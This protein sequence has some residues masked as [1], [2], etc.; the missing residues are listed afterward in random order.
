VE[1]I[2]GGLLERGIERPHQLPP[3]S[4]SSLH[5]SCGMSCWKNKEIHDLTGKASWETSWETTMVKAVRVAGQKRRAGLH[6][7][8][9]LAG[10]R[11]A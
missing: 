1:R 5:T 11:I 6:L 3:Q 9:S 10:I 4:K 2:V 8:C 7:I